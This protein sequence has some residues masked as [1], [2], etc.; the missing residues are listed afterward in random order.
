MW[1]GS[2]F[3]HPLCPL[4][5]FTVTFFNVLDLKTL[6]PREIIHKLEYKC[7]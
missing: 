4:N 3:H 5:T 7:I 1:V 6:S 2:A